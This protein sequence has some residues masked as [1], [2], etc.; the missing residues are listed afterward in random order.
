MLY[1][2]IFTVDDNNEMNRFLRFI[3]KGEKIIIVKPKKDLSSLLIDN[4]FIIGQNGKQYSIKK[5]G[6]KFLENLR[7]AFS[8]SR[9]RAS[10]VINTELV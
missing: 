9:M 8:G 1:C 4:E 5:D 2:D 7:Y 6:I 3:L 10:K